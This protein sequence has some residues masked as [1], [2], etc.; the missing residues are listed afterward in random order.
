VPRSSDAH[1]EEIARLE[2]AVTRH[3]EQLADQQRRFLI[4]RTTIRRLLASGRHILDRF[5]TYLDEVLL[6]TDDPVARHIV[7]MCGAFIQDLTVV[8]DGAK[9]VEVE[10]DD[11]R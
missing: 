2:A 3:L 1:R 8:F 10:A 6:T 4:E 11:G 5:E 9:V 7:V